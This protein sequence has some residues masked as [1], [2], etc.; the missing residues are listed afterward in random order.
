MGKIIKKYSLI[1]TI[2]LICIFAATF[3][4]EYIFADATA[5]NWDNIS[6]EIKEKQTLYI[7]NEFIEFQ[8]S[9]L[10]QLKKISD[11]KYVVL[12]INRN[13]SR[14]SLF[15][16]LSQI[17]SNGTSIEI[18]DSSKNSVAWV[19]N[20][21]PHIPLKNIVDSISVIILQKPL[22]TYLAIIQPISSGGK[23]SGYIA[24]KRLFDVNLPLSNRFINKNSFSNTFAG[25]LSITPEFQFSAT[26]HKT[27]VNNI[28][29]IPLIGI[30]RSI[31]GNAL[32]PYLV[33][34]EYREELSNTIELFRSIIG[35]IIY[36]LV[37]VVLIT[38]MKKY[39]KAVQF[40]V[41]TILVWSARYLLI[42]LNV[43]N[44]LFP[45]WFSPI[46]YASPFG[47][48]IVRSLGD[49]FISSIFI[50]INVFS[51][52]YFYLK[53]Y[54]AHDKINRTGSK[55]LKIIA[56]AL[57]SISFFLLFRAMAAIFRS[58]VRDSTISL[59]D[60]TTLLPNSELTV[61]LFGLFMTAVS[62]VLLQIVIID[63][64]RRYINNIFSKNHSEKFV[65]AITGIILVMGGVIFGL[66]QRSP[67]L[68]LEARAALTLG[69]IGATLLSRNGYL[70]KGENRYLR[71]GLVVSI[72]TVLFMIPALRAEMEYK[73]RSSVENFSRTVIKPT[74][75]W[76]SYLVDQTISECI[77]EEAV[78]IIKTNN[79][80]EYSALAFKKWARSLLSEE[81]NNC[82]IRYYNSMG[83]PISTFKIGT[84]ASITEESIIRD[85]ISHSTLYQVD[86]N[87]R[88]V[89]TRWQIR[90]SVL[91]DVN[92]DTI[93]SVRVEV[94]GNK[95]TLLKG[96]IPE[97]LRSK[98]KQTQVGLEQPLMLT[99][100]FRDTIVS[101]SE[102]TF[103]AKRALPN[104]IAEQVRKHNNLWTEEDFDDKYYESF[105]FRDENE[106]SEG[107][108]YCLARQ[109]PGFFLSFFWFLR[110]GFIFLI[111]AVFIFTVKYLW[112][113]LRKK[114]KMFSFAEKLLISY[115]I[116][117]TFPVLFFSY[118][119]K[120]TSSNRAE[121]ELL[122]QLQDQTEI[123]VTELKRRFDVSTPVSISRV[124][125]SDCSNI[126]E[127]INI[128]FDIYSSAEL[129]ST[130]KPELYDAELLDSHLDASAYREL[131]LRERLFYSQ[132]KELGNLAYVVGYRPLR[133]VDGRIIG[134]VSVPTLLKQSQ[135]DMEMVQSNA[136][137]FSIF[138]IGFAI[139]IALGLILS[140]QFGAPI[141]S[142][143]DAT[144]EIARGN[145]SYKRTADRADE[146]G[147]LDRAF[148]KMSHDLRNK[149]DQ[150]LTAQRE[151]AWREMAKQVAHEIKNPLTPMKL[152]LQHLRAAFHDR[153]K[154]LE[155]ILE[156][157]T[158]TALEQ[159]ETLSRIATE[160]SHM[161]KMPER[162][163]KPIDLH[164]IL[165]ETKNLFDEYEN[166]NFGL[167]LNA[168]H[169]TIQADHDEIRRAFVN[170]LKN[171]VQALNEKGK[172]TITSEDHKKY[173]HVNIVD[174]GP[175]MNREALEHLFELNF[176]T[177][178]EG[179]GIG[180]A[181]VKKT[182]TDFGG[183]IDIKSKIGGGVVVSII[184]PLI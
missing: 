156:K 75:A 152:S 107:S 86:K 26:N 132:K 59:N 171:S 178:S 51:L 150:L 14:D 175:G 174:D 122:S 64:I 22:F 67:L 118:Y 58:A 110:I 13:G 154:N 165:K 146:F 173:I 35:I 128:D 121:E 11:D 102:E 92:G 112:N 42:W 177:K 23:I 41:I 147:E 33:V 167:Y 155:D 182:V 9:I 137:L 56:V 106:S 45:D 21:G 68:S 120:Q 84:V 8:Q 158:N 78:R 95:L 85:S 176:S 170:I 97:I 101:S 133:S 12:G 149:Q 47:L 6:S 157:V 94:T 99:E 61:L 172:I 151:A 71:I 163:V 184:F 38:A 49:L 76:I 90:T 126:A 10:N 113:I 25:K 30:D 60:L 114:N 162:N 20:Y 82:V 69:L 111:F 43:S 136:V 142:L 27:T 160:F 77:D 46:Y 140:R 143:I 66:L 80:Q 74:N 98:T 134:V 108:V 103:Y 19:N 24:G 62:F 79:R 5:R 138:G 48:G 2:C 96:E 141:R 123:V 50:F 144:R 129:S 39:S 161:A 7:Q 31:L 63:I 44:Q 54:S 105:Y 109:K 89:N 29:S 72:T 55:F 139:S 130:S 18:F 166:I 37:T 93:G 117:A 3:M 57:L 34:D 87:I 124:Y 81:G 15:D 153:A 73:E 119:N 116:V 53:S 180:L 164:Q 159:I 36:L 168:S 127:D 4:Y 91:T 115:L 179:M 17:Q 52:C 169:S 145:L 83:G 40:I 183:T 100:Y 16:Y 181:I 70:N 28:Y 131:F 65:W 32:V 104:D 148:E 125:D 88:G 1:L 135:R